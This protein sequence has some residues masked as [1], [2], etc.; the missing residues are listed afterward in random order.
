MP[1]L[2]QEGTPENFDALI[3]A[4]A[5]QLVVVEFW[6]ENCPNCDVFEAQLPSLLE[7]LED[8]PVRLVRVHAYEH[9]ELAR[10]YAIFGVPTFVL[11]RAGERL[12]KMSQ[13]QGRE[14]WLT[15][16]REQLR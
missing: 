3:S 7:A 6:G 4:D 5:S 14:F 2:V 10:R 12:G 13:Y 15:V 16:I 11:F 9:P 8:A 1:V